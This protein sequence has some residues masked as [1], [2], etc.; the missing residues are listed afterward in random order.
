MGEFKELVG[1]ATE[2]YVYLYPLV[3]TDVTRHQ[4][5]RRGPMNSFMHSRVYPPGTYKGVV[6]P[7]FDTC[8]L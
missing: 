6:R 4:M 1:L 5:L 8:V 3:I 7:N 2:A